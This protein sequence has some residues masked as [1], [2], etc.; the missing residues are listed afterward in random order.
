[1]I[2][3]TG[4]GNVLLFSTDYLSQYSSFHISFESF[5]DSS[6]FIRFVCLR[7]TKLTLSQFLNLIQYRRHIRFLLLITFDVCSL[8]LV[9]LGFFLRISSRNIDEFWTFKFLIYSSTQVY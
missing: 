7:T 9:L 5:T 4:L 6:F 2:N 8:L 1:M 3:K